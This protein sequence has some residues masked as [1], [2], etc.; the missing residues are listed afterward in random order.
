[1]ADGRLDF[2][3]PVRLLKS[4]IVAS[5]AR[6]ASTFLCKSLWQTGRLGA[7]WEYLNAS[8]ED[9]RGTL[10]M[11]VDRSVAST[12]MKRLD[13]AGPAEYIA[14]LLECRTSSNGVFGV[15]ARFDDFESAIEEMPELLST[16]A[17]VT[18]IYVDCRDKLAQAVSIVRKLLT[19]KASPASG[20]RSQNRS[21]R[22]DRDLISKCLGWLERQRLAW[23]R[24][25]EMNGIDPFVVYYEDANADIAGVVRTVEEFLDAQNG[26]ADKVSLPPSRPENDATTDAWAERFT[27]EIKSGID[28]REPETVAGHDQLPEFSAELKLR[29]A[30][31]RG[32]RE[33]ADT[34]VFRAEVQRPERQQFDA[35]DRADF[36]AGRGSR[37]PVQCEL[38]APMDQATPDVRQLPRYEQVIGKNREL[39]LNACVL[40]L[41]SG[42][43]LW[44]LAA[45]EAGAA[46]VVG[47][48]PR[49]GRV[50]AAERAFAG[51]GITERS[52][53][54]V[55]M[56][57]PAALND[58]DPEAFD[59]ILCRRIL[60]RLDGRQFFAQLR[61]LRPKHVILDTSITPGNGPLI[62]FGWRE[63]QAE[64]PAEANDRY[65]VVATPNHEL[66]V[67][68]C[69][70]FG[71]QWRLNEGPESIPPDWAAR[72]DAGR[73]RMQTYVLDRIG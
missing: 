43:G 5:S 51:Y 18:Y 32:G 8:F 11:P 49:P 17:P 44:S 52:Y 3:G 39:L 58:T 65:T 7:P 62:R 53:R 27:R 56:D 29:P 71:F 46:H 60:E 13:G 34:Y 64:F 55:N 14:K 66:I 21:L 10:A 24:W 35:T 41:M 38:Q 69:D 54:F 19:S 33:P 9:S 72:R 67:L 16:L 48:D 12:M 45:L 36:G 61:H 68:L 70:Y 30:S 20:V 23:W 63:A 28:A 31:A 26:F 6:N 2:V 59:V 73:E 37:T 42:N 4:Y 57:I 25:F 40:D 1:M 22:Y 15:K 47:V 50:A